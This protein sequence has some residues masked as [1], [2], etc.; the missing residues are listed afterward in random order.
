MRN[1]LREL[2]ILFVVVGLLATACTEGSREKIREALPSG[3]SGLPSAFPSPSL[4]SGPTGSES[5]EPTA[6]TG[7]TESGEPTAPTGSTGPVE[8][9]TEEPTEAPTESPAEPTEGPAAPGQGRL[10]LAIIAILER[11]GEQPPP[12]EQP[13]STETPAPETTGP[14]G[15]TATGPTGGTTGVTGVVTGPTGATGAT[16]SAEGDASA[17]VVQAVASSTTESSAWVLLLFLAVLG[18]VIGYL[19]W[20]ARRG[21][22]HHG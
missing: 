9:P 5:G 8:T 22:A 7:P 19:W 11:L 21:R 10:I 1:G 17:D 18:G 3:V 2:V 13:S 14:E 16:G 4:P 15:E 6:P 12:S 20:R